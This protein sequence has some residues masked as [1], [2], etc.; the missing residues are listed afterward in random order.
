MCAQSYRDHV[1]K[2]S[3]VPLACILLTNVYFQSHHI[4]TACSKF[5]C[6]CQN[7]CKQCVKICVPCFDN[8]RAALLWFASGF[9]RQ[10]QNTVLQRFLPNMPQFGKTRH[11][12]TG[13]APQCKDCGLRCFTRRRTFRNSVTVRRT[14]RDKCGARYATLISTAVACLLHTVLLLFSDVPLMYS[15]SA[16]RTPYAVHSAQDSIVVSIL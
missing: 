12:F 6:R 15:C 13:K 1:L 10:A 2:P 8:K 7:E 3:S 4:H 5:F 16:Q 11:I 9:M 14:R